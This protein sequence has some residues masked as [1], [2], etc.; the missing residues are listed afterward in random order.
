[1]VTAAQSSWPGSTEYLLA[2][3]AWLNF[4]R[5]VHTWHNHTCSEHTALVSASSFTKYSVQSASEFHSGNDDDALS[6][7]VSVSPKAAH[8]WFGLVTS[9]DLVE[10]FLHLVCCC[11]ALRFQ[12]PVTRTC[13]GFFFSSASFSSVL[14]QKHFSP[15]SHHVKGIFLLLH[16]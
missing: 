13:I 11:V 3:T 14:K 9:K 6:S 8:L 1:M 16:P 10:D 2:W 12:R 7:Q 4:P 5:V 15:R